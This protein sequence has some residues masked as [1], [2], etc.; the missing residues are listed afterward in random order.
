MFAWCL[1]HKVQLALHNALSDSQLEIDTQ[2]QLENELYLFKK[3]TL[4]WRLF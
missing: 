4:K 3:A 1:L 2:K